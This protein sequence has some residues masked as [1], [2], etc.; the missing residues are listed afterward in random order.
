M[1][2]NVNERRK[3][4]INSKYLIEAN[5]FACFL[6]DIYSYARWKFVCLYVFIYK[7]VPHVYAAFVSFEK[8]DG[9]KESALLLSRKE[10]HI[11]F[12]ASIF[13]GQDVFNYDIWH[14]EYQRFRWIESQYR[15]QGAH[16][17]NNTYLNGIAMSACN[18]W[19]NV[20]TEWN[21]TKKNVT[22]QSWIIQKWINATA[23]KA[24]KKCLLKIH[25]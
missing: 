15:A 6:F 4:A 1:C 14:K 12:A 17:K 18:K 24:H 21:E 22:K 13:I 16:I 10:K 7:S 19:I 23:L 5:L 9:L 8:V 11:S 3:S 25:Y 2:R 20:W